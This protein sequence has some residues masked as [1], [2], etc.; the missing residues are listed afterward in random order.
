[1]D[2]TQV[3]I[4]LDEITEK[5]LQNAGVQD[6]AAGLKFMHGLAGKG[7]SDDD[8]TPLLIPLL[9]ALEKSP[10]ADRALSAFVHWFDAVGSRYSYLQFLIKNASVLDLFCLVMGCSQYFADLLARQPEYFELFADPGSQGGHKPAASMLREIRTLIGACHQTELKRDVL[11]RWK[12][13]QM[14]RIGVRDLGGFTDMPLTARE[15][16]NLADSCVQAACEIAFSALPT[17]DFKQPSSADPAFPLPFTVIAM[18]KLGGQELNYSSD[19]DL[20]FIHADDLPPEIILENGRTL[21]STAYLVR[22]AESIIKILAEDT[23]NGHVF[24]VDMRLRPEGRFGALSRSLSSSRAYYENWAENW[25]RQALIKARCI[26]G[27]R[28]LG[29]AFLDMVEPFVYRKQ[30]SKAFLQDI[31][32]N[33]RLIEE[34]CSVEGETDT[35]VKTGYGGIRDVEFIVQLKQLEFGGAWPR[36][37]IQNTLNALQRLRHHGFLTDYDTR[38]LSD[39]YQFMRTLEHRL[40][41]LHSFQTQ[42]LP[43]EK[44]ILERTK[45]AKRMGFRDLSSFNADLNRRRLRLHE[46]LNIL[47]YQETKGTEM[48]V[49]GA[50]DAIS[51]IEHLL[52]N[53][54]SAPVRERI[55]ELLNSMGFH[56]IPSAFR[57]LQLPM[58]G[59]EFGGMPPDTPVKFLK[60][61]RPLLEHLSRSP[62]PDD[63]L[64]G[65]E[66]MA[67]AVPNRAQLYASL[68][69]SPDF[70]RKLVLLASSSPSLFRQVCQ[71]QEWMEYL[72]GEEEIDS[73]Q[74][75]DGFTFARVL[76]QNQY[77]FNFE[78]RL[79]RSKTFSE[80]LAAAARIYQR[81][82]LKI[83]ARDIWGEI[84]TRGVMQ[85]LTLLAEAAL[86]ALLEICKQEIISRYPKPELS[87]IALDRIAIVGLGKLGGAELG[88]ASDWDVVFAYQPVPEDSGRKHE[89]EF[90]LLNE[91]VQ[92]MI[93][94]GTELTPLGVSIEIDLRLRPWGKKGALVQP[95]K[96]FIEY[97]RT[98]AETW[99]RQAA[100]K[101]R[102]AAG[103][104]R[105]GKRFERVL[106]GVSFARGVS[107]DEIIAV[108]AM[109]KRIES[110]RLNPLNQH[111]DLKLGF[112]GLSDIEW[113]AQ[114]LQLRLG[115]KHRS[116]RVSNTHRALSALAAVRALDNTE[117]DTLQSAYRILTHIR[118]SIRLT[119]GVARDQLP[120]D[121]VR[122]RVLARQL[123]CLDD[124]TS[125]A[126]LQLTSMISSTMSEVRQIFLHRF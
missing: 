52:P 88:Y 46:H 117:T 2:P 54:E 106:Q 37:R 65:I 73:M 68:D 10:D 102:F 104:L 29:E 21:E 95:I 44:D 50:A 48:D 34:K 110:E 7:I 81:E 86:E 97:Y 75:A 124:E 61:L 89:H 3:T 72:F 6:S 39:D 40:Q 94:V 78:Q 116:V 53:M 58:S 99:E 45:L 38:E 115:P 79:R 32:S 60:I 64:A 9:N 85:E 123:G 22:I 41:L 121:P 126:E 71:H 24:R 19:I 42:T 120:D 47:F 111:S 14:L 77:I 1:M 33:K 56:N 74:E 67:I 13:R 119:L 12:A 23:S 8:L 91:L 101:A 66:E 118:N 112:G 103:N 84:N 80:R 98:D 59:N 90:D 105:V 76:R 27:D 55:A 63:G 15:F 109:K 57:A 70:L 114:I 16:S 62:S 125:T 96:S 26:A 82:F 30:V 25:E 43:S 36:V 113:L 69:E 108:R 49:S 17:S 11:R 31:R 122:L 83:G 5:I 93:A 87:R 51:E 35:N 4:T 28:D 107:E 100:L 92:K 18:G 20:V